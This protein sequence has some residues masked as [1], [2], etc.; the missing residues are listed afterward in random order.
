MEQTCNY[1]NSINPPTWIDNPKTNT[2]SRKCTLELLLHFITKKSLTMSEN[3][4]TSETISSAMETEIWR[5]RHYDIN[6]SRRTRKPTFNLHQLIQKE[7]G[8]G[9]VE[10]SSDRKSLKQLIHG[11]HGRS[12]LEQHFNAEE[13][14]KKLQLQMVRSKTHDGAR[15]AGMVA[16]GAKLLRQ[17]VKHKGDK[18]SLGSKKNIILR[19]NK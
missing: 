16:R 19:F 10:E 9:R 6:M 18:T 5:R 14:G 17:L 2:P 12:S 11:D 4:T 13:D 1:I 8:N 3:Q 15:L 7:E